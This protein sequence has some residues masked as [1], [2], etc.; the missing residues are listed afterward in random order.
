MLRCESMLEILQE[1]LLIRSTEN[2]PES[3]QYKSPCRQR[4][5][6]HNSDPCVPGDSVTSSD[7]VVKAQREYGTAE[8]SGMLRVPEADECAANGSRVRRYHPR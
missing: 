5:R 6:N 7:D 3:W 2:P 8:Q 4:W 1:V